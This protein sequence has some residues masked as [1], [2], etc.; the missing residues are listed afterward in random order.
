MATGQRIVQD[1]AKIGVQVHLKVLPFSQLVEAA[2]AG[3]LPVMFFARS[4]TTSDA[5]EFLDPHTRCPDATPG[6]GVDNF[7]H[8]CDPQLDR[9]LEAAS[10]E[11][12]VETR[13]SLLQQA[14]RRVLEQAYYLPLLIRWA[15]LALRQP[16]SFTPR[17]DQNMFLADFTL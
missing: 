12:D 15:Y 1:W 6:L 3:R 4:C 16:L 7:P 9:L 14:Q 11:L 17:S 2:R 5:S 13:R 10:L 8:I